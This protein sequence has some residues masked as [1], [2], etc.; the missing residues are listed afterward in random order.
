MTEFPGLTLARWMRALPPAC[1]L[2]LAHLHLMASGADLSPLFLEAPAILRSF[3]AALLKEDLPVRMAVRLV[4]TVA[5]LDFLLARLASAAE[6]KGMPPARSDLPPAPAPG[7]MPW[8]QLARD[9]SAR[10]ELHFGP[11]QAA[12]WLRQALRAGA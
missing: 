7:E 1:G 5:S 8:P 10:A 6:A 2:C 12:R 3:E 4:S 11:E 9:F